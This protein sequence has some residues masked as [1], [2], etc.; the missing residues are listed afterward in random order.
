MSLKNIIPESQ[1]LIRLAIR[2][3][4]YQLGEKRDPDS[5]LIYSIPPI[6]GYSHGYEINARNPNELFRINLF[7]NVAETDDI[8]TYSLELKGPFKPGVL[9]D[10]VFVFRGSIDTAHTLYDGYRLLWINHD[11]SKVPLLFQTT[12]APFAL[13]DG[14]FLKLS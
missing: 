6:H 10:E 8:D 7:L 9:G 3:Y 12:G 5:C 4:N 14:S 13:V 2:E 11:L 1:F